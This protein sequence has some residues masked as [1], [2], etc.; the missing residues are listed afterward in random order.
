[1]KLVNEIIERENTKK[2]NFN[3][4][5]AEI[6][7][8]RLKNNLTLKETSD[9][10]CSIS[11][12]CKIERNDIN[13]NPEL[14]EK[15]CDKLSISDAELRTLY[16]L[17][18]I[19]ALIIKGYYYD[20][21]EEIDNAYSKVK[22]LDNYKASIIKFA[23]YLYYD[24]LDEAIMIN[25][26]LNQLTAAMNNT[27]LIVYALFSAILY[28]KS[29]KYSDAINI[30][31]RI[32]DSQELSEFGHMIAVHML[33]DIYYIG[34]SKRFLPMVI[35]GLDGDSRLMNH[36]SFD[37]LMLLKAKY[38]LMNGIYDEFYILK[39][40]FKNT[41]YEGEINLLDDI[42]N[43]KVS[44]PQD[45]KGI[46]KF[47]YYLAMY[48]HNSKRFFLLEK[49]YDDLNDEE[50]LFIKFLELTS[51]N[52]EE[53]FPVLYSEIFPTALKLNV[54]YLVECVSKI[55]VDKL[56]SDTRYKLAFEVLNKAY[57]QMRQFD[58]L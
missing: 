6:K 12:L 23:Y 39:K 31:K 17:N 29:H 2:T 33:C 50:V 38:F 24:K 58:T 21:K 40:S 9:N 34:N 55:L 57:K 19:E 56:C 53:M 36:K 28:K 27:D 18:Q 45:Y 5:G 13:L 16:N 30:L 20:D 7:A 8:Q 3:V 37:K 47:Y 10:V 48:H 42:Y 1:M 4:L 26:K 41:E 44:K 35:K 46:S 15:L 22:G 49:S 43:Y 11:Y 52:N 25:N 32:V 51:K 14:I 54:S